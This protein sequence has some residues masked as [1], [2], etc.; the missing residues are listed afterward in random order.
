V[1]GS[2]QADRGQAGLLQGLLPEA[3]AEE[4][5]VLGTFL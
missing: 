1:P 2:I 5:Q 4:R 3:Q